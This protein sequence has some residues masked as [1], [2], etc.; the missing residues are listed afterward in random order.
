MD[1]MKSKKENSGLLLLLILMINQAFGFHKVL[2][3]LVEPSFCRKRRRS[4]K[5]TAFS[6]LLS[7]F[8]SCFYT[9]GPKPSS[10]HITCEPNLSLLSVSIEGLVSRQDLT[11]APALF[12]H[13]VARRHLS[14]V[15][16]E[17]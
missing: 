16:G 11:D 4:K 12:L 3:P 13:L 7:I 5:E 10:D 14:Q 1:Q 9:I 2:I 8:W 6:C 17:G 15:F